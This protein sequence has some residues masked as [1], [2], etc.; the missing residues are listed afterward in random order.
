MWEQE[1]KQG[2]CFKPGGGGWGAA[3]QAPA[4]GTLTCRQHAL[5][6]ARAVGLEAQADDLPPQ[7]A[8]C[9]P[10][11]RAQAQLLQH[12]LRGLDDV[13]DDRRLVPRWV[14]VRR[15]PEACCRRSVRSSA[16]VGGGGGAGRGGAGRGWGGC[17]VACLVLLL[18][19]PAELLVPL[20]L[21]ALLLLLQ[22][23]CRPTTPSPAHPH[24]PH[25]QR[26]FTDC[27]A[28]QPAVTMAAGR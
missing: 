7:R 16:C 21:P 25:G 10:Q 2:S 19:V 1:R 17:L 24:T 6:L 8:L 28:S 14:G 18:L 13:G 5:A 3:Q 4:G 9:K 15:Q 27:S 12:A 26:T 20:L 11:G 22:H 23:T